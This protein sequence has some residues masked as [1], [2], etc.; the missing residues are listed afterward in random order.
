[1]A[2]IELGKLYYRD[3]DEY[4]AEYEKR[5]HSDN[6]IKLD[7]D[8][9]GYQAFICQTAEVFSLIYDIL[10]LDKEIYGIRIRLPG[11]ALEQYSRKCLVDEIVLTN[12]IEGVSSSRKKIGETLDDLEEQSE[13]RGRANV[14]AGIVRKYHALMSRE[15]VS[16]RTCQDIRN[17][18][19]Q[20]VSDE[21]AG[22]DRDNIPDGAIFRKQLSEL[23]N[24]YGK[25]IHRGKYPESEIIRYM[26]K[27]LS[28][29]NG[30][31]GNDLIRHC[32]F[33]YLFEYIHPFYDWNG[34]TGRFILSYGLTG[35]LEYL[36]AF[37]ISGVIRENLSEYYRA[38]SV[39]NDPR[40]LGDLTPFLM[41]MLKMINSASL[42][43]RDSLRDKLCRWRNYLRVYDR[44]CLPGK[45]DEALFDYLVQASL[46]SEMGISI[47]ELTG[48]LEITENTLRKRLAV[49]ENMHLLTIRKSGNRKFYVIDLVSLDRMSE[50]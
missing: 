20:V 31:D 24:S 15:P 38:F 45:D 26:E 46:F 5:F 8:I 1:M 32:V 21:V 37:R 42:D 2:Y 14:F 49:F 48:L 34:R 3:R 17:I 6:T 47:R 41:M 10:I 12:K 27:A 19:D 4:R 25:V 11:K 28:F 29:L 13:K 7:F 18:Y 35:P 16:L 39:C 9:E 33:H 50:N 23:F 44:L 36:L 30:N 40:N 22:T 43:L